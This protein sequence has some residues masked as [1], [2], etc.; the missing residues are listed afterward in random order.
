MRLMSVPED[1]HR[2]LGVVTAD[3]SI[4][5][6]RPNAF[7]QHGVSGRLDD[8]SA[9]GD[10]HLTNREQG[11]QM[12]RSTPELIL[13]HPLETTVPTQRPSKII[14]VGINYDRHAAEAGLPIPEAPDVRGARRPRVRDRFARMA[15]R[16]ARHQR[17]HHESTLVINPDDVALYHYQGCLVVP[18]VLSE[19]ELDMV[20]LEL[21]KPVQNASEVTTNDE[22]FDLEDSHTQAAPK[23]RRIKSPEAIMPSVEALVRHPVLLEILTQLIGPGV[24]AADHTVAY[25]PVPSPPEKPERT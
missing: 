25:T 13:S 15:N 19:P 10:E 2:R 20:R 24:A 6:A 7:E 8:L 9:S 18:D 11:S 1:A 4:A 22:V 14:C 21:A 23:V 12:A 17:H 5:I 16:S 3:G